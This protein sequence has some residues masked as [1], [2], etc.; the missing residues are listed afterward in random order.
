V[1]ESCVCVCLREMCACVVVV[2]VPFCG[3]RGGGVGV[4]F[5]ECVVLLVWWS[6]VPFLFALAFELAWC[7]AFLRWVVLLVVRLLARFCS[8]VYVWV[9]LPWMLFICFLE[10]LLGQEAGVQI[11]PECCCSSCLRLC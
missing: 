10:Q 8:V 6:S 5:C 3:D 1:C 4:V 2:L 7:C 11:G 9:G